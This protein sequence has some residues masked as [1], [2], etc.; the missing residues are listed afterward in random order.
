MTTPRGLRDSV[1]RRIRI[2]RLWDPGEDVGV[3]VSGG[4]DS[5][6]L[7]DILCRTRGIHGGRIKVLSIDH[8]QSATGLA[9]MQLTQ[10]LSDHHDV[11]FLGTR[12]PLLPNASEA[13]MREARYRWLSQQG[14]DV[15]ALGHHRD[16]LAETV[17]LQIIRGSGLDGFRGMRWRHQERVRPMLAISRNDILNYA[18]Q[19]GL[20]WVDD[21]SNQDE[22]FTRNRVR[23]SVLPLLETLRPG[24]TQAIARS[25]TLVADEADALQQLATEWAALHGS[26]MPLSALN[27]GP[28]ALVRRGLMVRRPT[29]TAGQIDAILDIARMGHGS[30][31]LDAKC[32]AKIRNGHLTLE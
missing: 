27:K 18:R 9:G 6:T 21:P 30:V 7:L 10:A 31:E 4:V 20:E 25:A 13:A 12:L 11:P 24:A 16:D 32:I 5:V 19:V 2:H 15:I 26:Q 17:L 14:V 1:L 8:A 3:A 28:A 23:H 22:T 29:L